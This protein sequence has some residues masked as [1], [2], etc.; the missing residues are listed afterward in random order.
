MT[1]PKNQTLVVGLLIAIVL[2]GCTFPPGLKFR[3]EY[4][5]QQW[6]ERSLFPRKVDHDAFGNTILV[7]PVRPVGPAEPIGGSDPADAP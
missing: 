2:T 7:E 1:R 3:D 5:G 6:I 4:W